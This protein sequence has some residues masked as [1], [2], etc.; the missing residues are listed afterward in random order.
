MTT[1]NDLA[2]QVE[3]AEDAL[4]SLKEELTELKI[5]LQKL[6]TNLQELKAQ[7]QSGQEGL[8]GRW[9]THPKY[10]R[11]IIINDKPNSVGIIRFFYRSESHTSGTDV[12]FTSVE[13]LTLDPVILATE[14]DFDTAPEGTIAEEAEV[15]HDLYVKDGSLWWRSCD[16]A[17]TPLED[18]PV[19]RVVRWGGEMGNDLFR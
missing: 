16:V 13:N 6:K 18:M 2:V 19:C 17:A 4:T 7:E 5:N 10:G 15:P 8:F 14:Q 11:G 12:V 9:A 3:N 1:I